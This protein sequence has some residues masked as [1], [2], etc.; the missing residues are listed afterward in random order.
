MPDKT[1][2]EKANLAKKLAEQRAKGV[3]GIPTTAKVKREKNVCTCI[4]VFIYF[5]FKKFFFIFFLQLKVDEFEFNV[6]EVKDPFPPAD[7][8]GK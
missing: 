4:S 3:E 6:N 8:P 1:S 7:F 5:F 2:E